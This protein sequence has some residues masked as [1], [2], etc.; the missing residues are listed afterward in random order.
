M[1]GQVREQGDAFSQDNQIKILGI[2][3]WKNNICAELSQ[4]IIADVP[5][6]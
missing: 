5:R 2:D 4:D 3:D 1:G 6:S